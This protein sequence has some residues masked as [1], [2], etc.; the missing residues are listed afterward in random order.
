MNHLSNSDESESTTNRQTFPDEVN[1][2]QLCE[3]SKKS[4]SP[5]ANYRD[6]TRERVFVNISVISP[7]F[8]DERWRAKY[9]PHT[10]PEE[11]E[12]I[13]VS[14]DRE[15]VIEAGLQWMQEHPIGASSGSHQ[16]VVSPESKD[17]D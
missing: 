12:T 16:T 6:P 5:G 17:G 8:N 3:S 4:G 14:T 7:V 15:E 9:N 1:G 13:Y 11:G 2:W 10:K